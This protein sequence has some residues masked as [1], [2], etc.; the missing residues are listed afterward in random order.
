M[1]VLTFMRQGRMASIPIG[2]GQG[3]AMN[4]TS[5]LVTG[6]MMIGGSIFAFAISATTRNNNPGDFFY[7]IDN[8]AATMF[9]VFGAILLLIGIVLILL[10]FKLKNDERIRQESQVMAEEAARQKTIQDIAEAVKTNIRVRCQ[11]CGA[12]NEETAL[13]C[14]SCGA[15]L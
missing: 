7:D 12:L 2:S 13:K 1:T 4:S 9:A 5:A 15:S 10:S 11:Y 14:T 6:I 3:Q 8:E